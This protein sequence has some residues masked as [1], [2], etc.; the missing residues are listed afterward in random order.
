MVNC[1]VLKCPECGKER[2]YPT[3]K[4]KIESGPPLIRL[5]YGIIMHYMQSHQNLEPP[6]DKIIQSQKA[7]EVDKDLIDKIEDKEN[8]RKWDYYNLI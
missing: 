2:P 3:K 5:K 8:W 6:I 1:V 7:I 4:I